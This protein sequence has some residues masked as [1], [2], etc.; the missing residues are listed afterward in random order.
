MVKSKTTEDIVYETLFSKK[1]SRKEAAVIWFRK[2][3]IRKKL[4]HLFLFRKDCKN[5]C[6]TEFLDELFNDCPLA[7]EKK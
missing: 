3:E 4:I 5:V 2:D 7:P 1:Y 6:W